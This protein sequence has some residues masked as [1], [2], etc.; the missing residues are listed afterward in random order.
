MNCILID[1]DKVSRLVIEKY[2][3]KTDFLSILASFDNAVDCL[4]AGGNKRLLKSFGKFNIRDVGKGP[5]IQ[6]G[7]RFA[8]I[9]R[10]MTVED[11][12]EHEFDHVFIGKFDQEPV[13]NKE[14]AD[15]WKWIELK[16]LIED[17]IKN[18]KEY[19]CWFKIILTK[20]YDK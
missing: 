8:S 6:Y 20:L 11:L 3:N 9:P 1:D 12:T 7:S 18:P 17:I 10:G 14:E 19:T 13:L 16:Q 2:I 5:F 15:G 4:N